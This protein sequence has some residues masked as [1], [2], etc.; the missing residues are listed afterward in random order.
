MVYTIKIV[1]D[2]PTYIVPTN[3]TKIENRY[4]MQMV[5]LPYLKMAMDWDLSLGKKCSVLKSTVCLLHQYRY[6]SSNKSYCTQIMKFYLFVLIIVYHLKIIID[7]G[8]LDLAKKIIRTRSTNETTFVE[9]S[10][11]FILKWLPYN[12]DVFHFWWTLCL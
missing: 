2:D 6:L 5:L 10:V 3:M 7:R 12:V 1:S 11:T 8:K 9:F 4:R